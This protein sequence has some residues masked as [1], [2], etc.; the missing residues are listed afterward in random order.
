[1]M[2][3][4]QLL[5]S[6]QTQIHPH[7]FFFGEE[8][9]LLDDAV[10]RVST[11]ALGEG[12]RDFNFDTFDL[13]LGEVGRIRDVIETLPLMTERRVVVLK[14]AHL[15]KEAAAETL[16]PL[17]TAP[18]HT[19]TV[20]WTAIKIDKRKKFYKL[21]L[22]KCVSVE[23]RR[24]D[25]ADIP[26]WIQHLSSR[27]GVKLGEAETQLL[28]DM[29]GPNLTDLNGELQKLQSYLGER[30]QV[31][32]QDLLQSVSRL[33]SD[34]VFDLTDAIGRNDCARA[35]VCL[36]NLL[37]NGENEIGILSLISRHVRI[38]K[39]VREGMEQGLSGQRLS[40]RVGVPN[41]FLR[42]YV[43][44]A[45][46]W[47]TQKIEKTYQAL[48]DTDRALKSAPISSHIWLENFVLRTC[49]NTAAS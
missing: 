22:D 34:S 5:K 42:N 40:L 17:L 10:A 46:Q 23:M 49:A 41:Y 13:E 11:V 15:L 4:S 28:F 1:M 21:L 7:Y 8:T 6:I 39:S 3:F 37:D 25:E 32:T 38:L 9:F 47:P 2:N 35:L 31:Q 43:D 36:A 19:T 12:L 45:R 30:K 29:V 27:H 33:R 16:A 26:G 48:L 14:N 24:P 20:I 44:Q 18:V